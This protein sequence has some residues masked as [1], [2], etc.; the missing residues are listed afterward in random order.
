[1][2]SMVVSLYEARGAV[3]RNVAELYEA[4]SRAMLERAER[5][6]R[7][8]AG[9]AHLR[10]V[11]QAIFF[12]AHVAQRR[13]IEEAQLLA[14]AVGLHASAADRLAAL[15]WPAHEG[16]PAVGEYSEVRRGAHAGRRGVVSKANDERY[17]VYAV[18]FED[19]TT[20]DEL[21][22]DDLASSGLSR[23]AFDERYH[24]ELR[25]AHDALPV[26]LREALGVVRER[27]GRGRLPLLS[28]LQAEPLQLQASHLSFQ[29]YHAACALVAGVPLPA[30]A[31]PWQ[32]TVWWAN[33]LRFGEAHGA[34]FQAGLR[35][36]AGVGAALELSQQLA[37]GPTALRAVL[38]LAE[39]ATS[40]DLSKNE[41]SAEGGAE[42]AKMVAVSA[43]LTK[44][45]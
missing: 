14:A 13:V 25:A 12:E 22:K 21:R 41:L 23:A 30:G 3:P 37:A 32:W 18:A 34:A 26:E 24:R 29:E 27:V 15:R 4:A 11:L 35:R 36:A 45:K 42:V 39:T 16:K 5:K 19:G 43:S 31:L 7:G 40:V 6:E 1:M 38:L 9:A 8:A 10:G 17:T 28:L 2:L 33:A 44:I 20:A